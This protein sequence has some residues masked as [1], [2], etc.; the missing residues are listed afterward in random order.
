MNELNFYDQVGKINGWD[1]SNLKMTS[2]G[3]QW[4]FYEEVT[5]RCTGSDILLDVGTGGGEKILKIASSLLLVVGIDFSSGMIE[6]AGSNLESSKAANVR[7]SQ[8]SAHHLHFP[9]EFF[10]VI[11]SCQAPLE[12]KEIS[13][14]LKKGGI[15]LTQQVSEGD[16]VNL[17]TAFG[18]GQAFGEGDGT[19]KE[20]YVKELIEAGFAD[21]KSYEYDA[22]EYY[23]RPE[24]LI[25][26]LTHTPIIPDFG[27]QK[28]DYDILSDYIQRNTTEKGIQTNAKRFLVIAKK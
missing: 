22:A 25:F 27:Q 18:R 6:R 23:Q 21:V 15:F 7:F 14:A 19:L 11:S 5:K 28:K 17:K 20:R 2:E 12:A 8:M 16:K 3:V 26:L 1:F 4:D 10:D 9:A 24:D 13:K